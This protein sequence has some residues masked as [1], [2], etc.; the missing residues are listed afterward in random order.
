M[1]ATTALVV[2][3]LAAAKMGSDAAK[4]AANTQKKGTDAAIEEQ[5]LAREQYQQNIA[6]YL[7]SGT[8]ALTQLGA[9]NGGDYSSF[10]L[11]PDYQFTLEQGMKIG[12]RSAAANG[13]LFSGGH[14]ADLAKY[15][16]GLA[17]QEYNNYYNKIYNLATMGQ[18][19]AAG[20]GSAAMQ[21][22]NNIGGYLTA[23]ANAAANGTIG[24]ANQWGNALTGLA[25]IAGQYAGNRSSYSQ[26]MPSTVSPA[27]ASDFGNN[28]GWLTDGS[29]GGG[30][31]GYN[32]WS[33]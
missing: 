19:A 11:S 21:S 26:P 10:N 7:T 33:S 13:S 24:S 28:T 25:N 9:L 1:A 31:N 5:R 18:N 16:Q 6:P 22:A 23:G 4:D 29:Y 3:T 8:N 32:G 15:A 17:S 27:T 20:A 12:D 30:Y 14:Q 2:G